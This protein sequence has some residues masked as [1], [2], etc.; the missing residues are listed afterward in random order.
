MRQRGSVHCQKRLPNFFLQCEQTDTAKEETM[1]D[2]ETVHYT[3]A[4]TGE[5][6]GNSGSSGH[7]GGVDPVVLTVWLHRRKNFPIMPR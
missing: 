2:G 5:V 3:T 1:S 4:Q 6:G 7:G